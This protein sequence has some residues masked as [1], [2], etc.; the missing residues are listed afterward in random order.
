MP[1]DVPSTQWIKLTSDILYHSNKQYLLETDYAAKYI[2]IRQLPEPAPSHIVIKVL[3][4]ILSEYGSPHELVI[5]RGP[6]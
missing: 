2:V 3:K 5:D 4:E 1:H 6:H